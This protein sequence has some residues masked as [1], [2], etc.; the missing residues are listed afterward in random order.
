MSAD[1]LLLGVLGLVVVCTVAW[2]IASE[3]RERRRARAAAKM[4]ARYRNDD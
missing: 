4:A 2:P 3:L 1:L